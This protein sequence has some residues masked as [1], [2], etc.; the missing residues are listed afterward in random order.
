MSDINF[1]VYTDNNTLCV[2]AYATDEVVK[3]LE[4]VS[5]KLFKWITD[6][7]MKANQDKCHLIVSKNENVSIHYRPFEIKE[8][9]CEKLLGIK[10]DSR[11]NFN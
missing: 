8:A 3:R 7:Q 5:V 6:N 9:N 4:T 10:V 1:A 11:V 2:L